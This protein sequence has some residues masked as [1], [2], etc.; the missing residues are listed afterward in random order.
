LAGKRVEHFEL[1]FAEGEVA[2]KTSIDVEGS[3]LTFPQMKRLVDTNVAMMD[4][5]LP[6]IKAVIQGDA[7]PEEAIAPAFAV[8]R[9]HYD[10]QVPAKVRKVHSPVYTHELHVFPV[11]R[12]KG[13][14]SKELRLA[15]HF[16]APSPLC[17]NR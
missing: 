10:D 5:Y 13:Q 16:V 1:D 15:P 9:Y 12:G 17:P 7:S 11:A 6:G 3:T 14:E 2:Y 8:D 4:Q